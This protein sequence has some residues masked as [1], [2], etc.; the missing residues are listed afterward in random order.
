MT[1]TEEQ[2]RALL[3]AEAKVPRKARALWKAVTG[4]SVIGA[5][6]TQDDVDFFDRVM[7]A[8]TFVAVARRHARPLAE[9]WLAQRAR[10]AELEQGAEINALRFR[11]VCDIADKRQARIAEL[12]ALLRRVLVVPLSDAVLM[13]I[14]AAMTAKET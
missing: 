5:Q 11:A 14:E 13:E 8:R 4:H 2:V 7:D 12:E 3:A 1:I 9:S 6:L 10:I